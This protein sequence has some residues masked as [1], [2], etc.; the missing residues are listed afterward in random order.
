[1]AAASKWDKYHASGSPP[2]ESGRPVSQFL[3]ALSS[4]VM[5]ATGIALELGCGN[6]VSTLELCAKSQYTRVYGVDISEVALQ[7]A[8]AAAAALGRPCVLRQAPVPLAQAAS[9]DASEASVLHFVLAD[10]L[11]PVHTAMWNEQCTAVFDCQFFHAVRAES[12]VNTHTPDT[13]A[14][15]MA[16]FLVPHVGRLLVLAGN[17]S[18][19]PR[20]VPGP[21]LLTR[22]ELVGPFERA[23]LTLVSLET[24]R[25]DATPAYGEVPPLAWAAVF[26]KP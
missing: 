5:P 1:M 20:V 17:A 24:T 11:D 19:P 13:V 2:W 22:D 26:A 23:G 8:M 10:L 7:R 12:R 3:S 6:G 25:F 4:S 18:E 16:N 15:A 14:M 21:T 9:D